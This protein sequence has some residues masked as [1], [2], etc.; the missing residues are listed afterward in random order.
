VQRIDA[1]SIAWGLLLG[2]R[3]RQVPSLS[4][5][6]AG[7]APWD[8]LV[9]ESKSVVDAP[10]PLILGSDLSGVVEAVG[11]GVT[12]FQPGDKIYGVTDPQ[13]IGAYRRL[14]TL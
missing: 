12:Q 14:A 9:R 2:T 5:A 8:A 7:V 10:F 6:S 13:F 11:P 1:G 4:A 3:G